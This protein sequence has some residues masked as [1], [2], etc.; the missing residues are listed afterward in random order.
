MA[1]TIELF[2]ITAEVPEGHEDF[3]W[4]GDEAQFKIEGLPDTVWRSIVFL[5]SH[6]PFFPWQPYWQRR[7]CEAAIAHFFKESENIWDCDGSLEDYRDVIV[8]C[9]NWR[10]IAEAAQREQ[11]KASSDCSGCRQE[12]HGCEGNGE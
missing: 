3:R 2:G 10:R 4:V 12:S 6:N 9:N 5:C 11:R 1:T 8:M 7:V